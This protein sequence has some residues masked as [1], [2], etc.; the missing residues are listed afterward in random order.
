MQDQ[1]FELLVAVP[2]FEEPE[3]STHQLPVIALRGAETAQEFAL[4]PQVA[5]PPLEVDAAVTEALIPF[6]QTLL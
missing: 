4:L 5:V 3:L 6:P 2:D 1:V